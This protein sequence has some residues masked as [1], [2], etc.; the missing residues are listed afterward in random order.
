MFCHDCEQDHCQQNC[1][2]KLANKD[3]QWICH[4]C[5]RHLKAGNMPPQA[6]AN[7]LFLTPIPSELSN[8]N[9]LERQLVAL[10]IPFMKLLSLPRGGQKGVKGPVVN[11]PSDIISVTTSLP[12]NINEAQLIKVKLKRKSTYKGHYTFRWINPVRVIE[13]IQHLKQN[14]YWYENVTIDDAWVFSNEDGDLVKNHSDEDERDSESDIQSE[15]EPTETSD[16][17][18]SNN[19]ETPV[20]TCFQ[21]I[22]MGQE[23][24]DNNKTLCIAPAENQTQ[25]N[26]FQEDDSDAMAFPTLLPNGHFGLF[27]NRE[28]KLTP[29]KYFNARLFSAENRVATNKEFIFFAKYVSEINNI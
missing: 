28:I 15:D 17:S 27:E 4:T 11:V 22:D 14:N 6:Q 20:E 8:L 9:D 7:N 19:H 23:V 10:R 25:Q 3:K 1:W 2:V 12:R 18:C 26:I 16:N 21:P 13:A 29:A 5:H 24:L